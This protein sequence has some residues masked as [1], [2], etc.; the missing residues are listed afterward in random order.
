MKLLTTR[1]QFIVLLFLATLMGASSVF[2]AN[3]AKRIGTGDVAPD[4]SLT[5]H[6]G[7]KHSLSAERGKRPVVL[8]FYRGHW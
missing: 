7:R 1:R 6:E 2:A 3:T 8:V 5:D 4:F